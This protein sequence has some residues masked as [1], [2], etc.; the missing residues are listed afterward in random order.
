MWEPTFEV[1]P[2]AGFSAATL[3]FEDTRGSMVSRDSIGNN[4]VFG[5]GDL[6]WTMAGRGILH[7]QRPNGPQAH[8]HALQIFVNLP[9]ALKRL[10]PGTC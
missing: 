6:H 2:H 7:T 9:A 5:A 1:H 10:P 8:I 4:A 3:V